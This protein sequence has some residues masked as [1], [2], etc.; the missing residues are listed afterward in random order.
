LLITFLLQQFPFT[1][2]IVEETGI[3]QLGDNRPYTE[4]GWGGILWRWVF[5]P[6]SFQLWFIFALF[7]YNVMYPLL[8]WM[9]LKIPFVWFPIAFFLWFTFFNVRWVEGQGFFF[10]SIGILLQKKNINVEE[11]P[12]WFAQGLFWII[13]IG[14]C[15]IKTF[16]AFEL[17]SSLLSSFV[18]IGLLYN[19]ATVSGILAIW[20]GFDA[21]VQWSMNQKWFTQA[22]AFSFFI[23]GL[24][25]P[26]M[27][28]IMQLAVKYLDG[29]TGHRLICYVLVP[30]L[31][32]HCQCA[33]ESPAILL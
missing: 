8:R 12:R 32:W 28:Y 17:D 24:H 16:M 10:F 27:A 9:V 3:D 29:L 22:S 1:A 14:T 11:K 21:V 18:I 7:L 25:I 15:I 5:T 6:I 4:I 19:I 23:Y 31:H 20:F 2:K 13:F 33:S 26:L 30:A